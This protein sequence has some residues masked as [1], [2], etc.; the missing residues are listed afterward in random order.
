MNSKDRLLYTWKRDPVPI[1][2][3]A[4][5]EPMAHTGIRFADRSSRS[6]SLYILRYPGRTNI[7]TSLI[8]WS[9]ELQ[10]NHV[11]TFWDVGSLPSVAISLSIV[12]N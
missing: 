3:Q 2:Q 7:R 12:I 5:L 6:E 9:M 1:T 8:F 11:R 4:E 10:G